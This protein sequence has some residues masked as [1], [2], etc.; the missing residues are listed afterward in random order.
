M[1]RIVLG[2]LAL[3]GLAI[4][5]LFMARPGVPATGIAHGLGLLAFLVGGWFGIAATG[6]HRDYRALPP[7]FTR[8]SRQSASRAGSLD[9]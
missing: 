7:R 8:C 6:W 5:I 1:K 9:P 3:T 2:A 4:G